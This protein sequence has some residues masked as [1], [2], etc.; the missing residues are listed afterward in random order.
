MQGLRAGHVGELTAELS[1]LI[2]ARRVRDIAPFPPRDV[3]LVLEGDPDGPAVRRLRLSADS[4]APRLHL[5]HGR[6]HRHKGPPGPFFQRLE[7]ELVGA[8]VRAIEQ[9]RQDRI[10]LIEFKDTPSG[11]RRALLLELTG[12]HANLILLGPGDEVLD[13]LVPPPKRKGSGPRLEL[14]RPWEPP[15]GRPGSVEGEPTLAETFPSPAEEAP[16]S[17]AAP[18]SWIVEGSLGGD[19]KEARH[20]R[21]TK[22][23]T[24]RLKRKLRR[25]KGLIEGLEQKRVAAEGA[26]RVRQDGE[27]LKSALGQVRRGAK[28]IELVDWF[29][30][31]GGQR[32]LELDPRRSPADNVERL[33]ARAKKLDRARASVA[34]ELERAKVKLARL[35]DL[36][37]Q[38]RAEDS[39]PEA[40]DELARAEGLLDKKQSADPRV[41]K[42]KKPVPR[43]PYKTFLVSGDTEVR[44]GRSAADND[45]LTFKHS[46]GSDL[47]L[48]TADCPGSHVILRLAKNAEPDQEAVIDAALLAVHFSPARDGDGVPVHV[49]RRKE[50]HKPRGAKAGLVTLSGGR[51]LQVRAQQARLEALLRRARGR[52]TPPQA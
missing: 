19:A 8:E 29:D 44:V 33:F 10:A 51:I 45:A 6:T 20:G 34:E 5:Q 48:H 15:P 27:L 24:S 37:E 31:D 30:P 11:K 16:G 28:E 2:S 46:K 47:W 1:P 35:E 36:M 22:E 18:L 42:A 26:E 17:I 14:G 40:L 4:D 32:T 3:L 43:L 23:L 12:R 21:L 52:E 25:A 7:E 41:K 50:V 9:V 39:D 49:V 13:M 38:A